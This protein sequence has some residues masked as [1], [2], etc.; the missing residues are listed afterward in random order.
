MGYK[1][2]KIVKKLKVSRI[3]DEILGWEG[4]TGKSTSEDENC[5]PLTV[6][7]EQDDAPTKFHDMLVKGK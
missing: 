6:L 4:P 1:L 7:D 2:Q 3:V 5:E